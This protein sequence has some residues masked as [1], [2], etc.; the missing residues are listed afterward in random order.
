MIL[1]TVNP[2][3]L[4]LFVSALAT[5]VPVSKGQ[6]VYQGMFRNISTVS[7]PCLLKYEYCPRIGY[8]SEW[9]C[10]Y[11]GCEWVYRCDKPAWG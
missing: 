7:T 4:I 5:T 10:D 6:D 8:K 11:R 9:C 2:L 3:T 1:P